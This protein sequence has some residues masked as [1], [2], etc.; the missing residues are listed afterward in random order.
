MPDPLTDRRLPRRLVLGSA[1]GLG[2]AA[3][4]AA[5]SPAAQQDAPAGDGTGGEQRT[6]TL[7]LW[8][9]QV[10]E[11]YRV[12]FEAF[13]EANPDIRVE[14]TLVAYA[15]YFTKLRT[16]VAGG[17]ADDLFW[18]NGSY[19][20]P[21]IDNG[22]L[23]EIGSA[24]DAQR[25]D[26]IQPAV[27]QYTSGGTLWGVPQLTDGGIA[28]YYNAELL[29]Q[30]GLTP[31]DL[32]DLTW[33]PG[34]GDGDT[35]LPVLQRL[36]V[37]AQ[38]RR[39]DEEGFDGSDPGSWGYSAAQDLQGIYYNFVGSAGGQ[40][41]QPDGTF[42]FDSPEGRDA[43]SYVVDLINTHQVSPAASNTN[44]NGDFTRDQ[45]LQGKIAL[46][47]SGI[48]NLKNVADGADFEWGIVPIPAGPAGRVSVVNNI[49]VAGNAAAADTEAATRVLQWLGSA[50]G[51]SYIGAEGAALP[52]VTGAQQSF[53]D[54]WAEQ[55]VDPSQFAEQG[56]Q[57]SI[58]APTGQNY[59]AALTAWKP[60]FDE[61]F[62][63][64]TPVEEALTQAQ[65]AANEAING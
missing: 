29:E 14:T 45:F 31:E 21:Y 37:D 1:V 43:F 27:E 55:D 32:T 33:V 47:Q 53:S 13:T 18:I 20:Q 7:R 40:F 19:I 25:G 17:N 61:M 48:Y 52:A 57:P 39:G 10:A 50:E 63:G 59:G 15:D 46:F 26:W 49:V 35:F 8:D 23:V 54:Y 2:A 38:G 11:A 12:S 22:N 60:F 51:A 30:A 58:G 56:A 4:V 28:I 5:C 6:V 9:E 65:Q 16:D 34:G 3:T 64:R 42:V 36:T 24:F 62:L 41:Q 44:D